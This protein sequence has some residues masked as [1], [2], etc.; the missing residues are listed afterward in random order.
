MTGTDHIC[1]SGASCRKRQV[2]PDRAPV[3]FFRSALQ[4]IARRT[5]ASLTTSFTGEESSPALDVWKG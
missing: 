4:Q 5:A 3:T 1:S 2:D